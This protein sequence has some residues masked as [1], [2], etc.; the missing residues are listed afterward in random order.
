M[1]S[2]VLPEGYAF[3]GAAII[4]TFWLNLWQTVRVGRARTKAGIAYPQLYAEA[5][6]AAASP[7]SMKFNCV[8]RAHQNTLEVV[9]MVL[10]STAI[11]ATQYPILAASLCGAWTVFRALY[12]IGYSTGDPSK[13]NLLGSSMFGSISAIGLLLAGTTAVV[14]I[15]L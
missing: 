3:A 2:I 13:R 14:K 11:V 4:A 1:P 9:P 15:L 5:S 6:Q 7:A 10:V 12:T 8:Q